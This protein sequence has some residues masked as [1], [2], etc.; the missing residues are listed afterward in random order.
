MAARKKK[1]GAG[2]GAAP[3]E[4]KKFFEVIVPRVLTIMR[5]TCTDMGGR[6]AV[7]VDGHGAWSLDFPTASVVP[8]KEGADV[9]VSLSRPQFDSLSS[10][11]VELAKLVADGAVK[12]EGDVKRIENVSLVLA[13]LA[14]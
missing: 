13:F 7:E 3:I 1:S 11:S 2:A 5:A 14:R 6:Y 10:S 8:G 12:C 4:P 9:T